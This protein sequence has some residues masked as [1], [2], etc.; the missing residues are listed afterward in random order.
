[1]WLLWIRTVQI[2]FELA[3][4][5]AHTGASGC[6]MIAK[7]K[8]NAEQREVLSAAADEHSV[9]LLADTIIIRIRIRL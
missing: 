2:Y 4:A 9:S 7:H 5:I 8:A 3:Y 1:M 6:I